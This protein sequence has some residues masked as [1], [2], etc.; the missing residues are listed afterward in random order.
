MEFNEYQDLAQKTA[1]KDTAVSLFNGP[2]GLAGEAGEVVDLLKK[3]LIHGHPLD[4]A[5]LK[6]ELGDVLWYL[7]EIAAKAE[8][9]LED[10]AIANIEKLKKRYPE[11]FSLT[12]SLAR[13]DKFMKPK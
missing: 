2:L 8:L 9:K 11:G 12:A 1:K 10:I 6:E 7:A 5:L 3:T 13:V 4:V